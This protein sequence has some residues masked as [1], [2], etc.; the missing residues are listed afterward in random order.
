MATPEKNDTLFPC[1]IKGI[2]LTIVRMQGKA[3]DCWTSTLYI[4]GDLSDTQRVVV[5]LEIR[6]SK[7]GKRV[8]V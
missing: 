7:K 1:G 2:P 5:N 3:N 6:E 4:I 8:R